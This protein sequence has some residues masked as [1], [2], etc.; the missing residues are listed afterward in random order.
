MKQ[1]WIVRVVILLPA[2]LVIVAAVPRLISGIALERA[3]PA[4]AY[5]AT[6]LPL[7]QADYAA[8]E[9]ALAQAPAADGE[10][11]IIQA[12]A[13]AGAGQPDA[14]VISVLET[15]LARSPG[16][17]RGWT[18]LASLLSDR[19]PKIAAGALSFAFALAPR[20]YYMVLPRTLVGAGL[21]DNLPADDRK[22]LLHDALGMATDT[23]RREDL[24]ALLMRRGGPA[25]VTRSLNG[26]PD[27]IRELNRSF[28]VELLNPR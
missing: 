25:L 14:A 9:A 16:D 22:M 10:T 8:T 3:F 1:G 28:A 4:S 15:A 6:N 2:I 20:D 5:I 26:N 27:A 7:S 24:R 13:A 21:W 19:S 12:E 18:L 23:N 11:H 17:A